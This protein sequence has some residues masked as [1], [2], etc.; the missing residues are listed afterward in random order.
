MR[1]FV[2]VAHKVPRDGDFS[3]NDLTGS[4]GRVD[5]IARS[6]GAALLLSHGI[7]RDTLAHVVANEN[8]RRPRHIRFEWDKVRYLNP[9]ERNGASLIRNALVR[10]PE[11]GELESS[12]GVFVARRG[13]AEVLEKAAKPVVLLSEGGPA[14]D[15]KALAAGA[16]FVL[17]DQQDLT[18]DEIAT[19]EKAG[20]VRAGLGERS[21]HTDHCVAVA[22]HRLD[23]ADGV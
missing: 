12:P 9:D 1:E 10:C 19:V 13:L 20:A 21:L 4:G 17:G 18:P 2:F 8:P 22:N 15:W 16:T 6:V 3:L 14:P 7:R 23:A 11:D 5:L